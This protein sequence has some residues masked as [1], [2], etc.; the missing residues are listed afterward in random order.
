[1]DGQNTMRT[2]YYASFP[3]PACNSRKV[4]VTGREWRCHDCKQPGTWD[5]DNEPVML[6]LWVK[7]KRNEYVA[8]YHLVAPSRVNKTYHESLCGQKWPTEYSLLAKEVFYPPWK[9][10]RYCQQLSGEKE[11]E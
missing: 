5:D 7:H 9:A 11:D 4:V 10:C 6:P 2:N 1:M 3:C 8:H